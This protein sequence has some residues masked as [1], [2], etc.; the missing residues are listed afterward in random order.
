M[1]LEEE[2]DSDYEPSDDE[3][4]EYAK[5]L[6]MDQNTDRDMFWLAREGLMV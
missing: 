6:G 3:V 1:I 2:L 5:W 4:L